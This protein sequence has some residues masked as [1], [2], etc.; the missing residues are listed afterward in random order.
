MVI[1]ISVSDQKPLQSALS[2]YF[3]GDLFEEG[4]SRARRGNVEGF[5]LGDGRTTVHVV[6]RHEDVKTIDNC[7][8]TIG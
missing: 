4:H 8:L 1:T 3:E 6:N 5:Q 7:Q 2:D